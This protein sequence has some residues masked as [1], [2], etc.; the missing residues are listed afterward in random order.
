MHGFEDFEQELSALEAAKLRRRLRTIAEIHGTTVRTADQPQQKVL[1]CSNNYLNLAEDE[2]IRKAAIEAIQEYGWGAGAS[3]LICGTL[4]PHTELEEAFA[5]WVG[6][7]R[8]LFFPSGWSANQTI[9]TALPARGDLVLMDH[10]CHASIVDAVRTSGADFRTYR[11]ESDSRLKRFLADAKYRRKYIVTESVFS[12]DGDLAR[13]DVLA[14]LKEQFGAVLIVD[15]AHGL[16]CFGPSG[17]GLAEEMGILEK[18]DILIAPL[19]KAAGCAGALAAGPAAVIDLLINRGRPLIYTTAAPAACAAASLTAIR[20]IQNE[21][22][23]R[24]RLAENAA[25]L[26]TQLTQMGLNIGKTASQIIPVIL[27]E[28]EKA[29]TWASRLENAGYFVIAIRPPTVPKGTARLRLSIQYAHT[30]EQMDGLC[31]ILKGPAE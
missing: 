31:R 23:R 24:Q 4:R 17:A 11:D 30:Q 19:G 25:Y 7:E 3:R 6:K 16:G 21:P 12:M 20:I 29:L 13:L 10:R 2:R 15:E 8:A 5:D 1:F 22:H 28:S 18:V 9:L 27:G 26:R 14:E